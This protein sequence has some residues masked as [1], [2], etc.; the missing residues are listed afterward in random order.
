MGMMGWLF[1]FI[2]FLGIEAATMALTTIWFAGGA[3]AGL[4]L[5]LLGASTEIQLAAFVIVSFALLALTRPMALRY[6]NRQTKKTNVESLIGKQAV[7]AQEVDNRRGTGMAVLEGQ[8]WTARSARD[9]LFIPEGTLVA[10]QEIRGVKLI[11]LPVQKEENSGR[12]MD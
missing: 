12:S 9:D 5:Y 7:I 2:V 8:E 1:A 3:L 10:V 11:V 4:I 6:V